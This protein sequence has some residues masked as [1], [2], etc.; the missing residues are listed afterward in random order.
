[1]N[2]SI[3]EFC[4][5]LTLNKK[6]S[7]H[8]VLAYQR[9]IEQFYRFLLTIQRLDKDVTKEDVRMFMT[10]QFDKGLS[11]R[12]MKRRLSSLRAYYAYMKD[13]HNFSQDPFLTMV[14]PKFQ[15]ALPKVL[16]DEQIQLLLKYNRLRKDDLQ[17]RDQAILELMFATGMR[18]SEVVALTL[19]QMNISGRTIHVIGKG[20]KERIVAFTKDAALTVKNYLQH[21]RKLLVKRRTDPLPT[22]VVFLNAKGN[23]LTIHGLR[24]ILL[25]IERKTGDYLDLHPHM[26]RHSFATYLLERGADLR[27]IQELLGHESLNTT[28][29]YTHVS[30]DKIREEY[31]HAH[32]RSKRHLDDES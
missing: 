17:E 13:R 19:Q 2:R 4:D 23:P 30:E 6:Y 7:P 1:M 8:T 29:I 20:N 3:K 32:P 9:D 11:K 21:S 14:S 22:N 10:L 5:F 15:V 27:V 12:T 26:L 28:Q 18:A 24:Y 25:S 31:Y 16:Y